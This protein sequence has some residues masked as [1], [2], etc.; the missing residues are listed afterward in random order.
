MM[1]GGMGFM[2]QGNALL[3]CN[4]DGSVMLSHDGI[5]IGQ[6]INIKMAQICAEELGI[7]VEKVYCP[8][9]STQ[10]TTG[11]VGMGKKKF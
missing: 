4:S 3:H 2:L 6:G 7:P 10:Q 9:V 5:E 1:P 11:I 8:H